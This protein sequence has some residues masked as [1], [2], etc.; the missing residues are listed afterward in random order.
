MNTV[1]VTYTE[2]KIIQYNFLTSGQSMT[3]QTN[4][5]GKRGFSIFRVTSFPCNFGLYTSDCNVQA[6]IRIDIL[7]TRLDLEILHISFHSVT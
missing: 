4:I 2:P 5:D 3:A 7:A 6:E 1:V